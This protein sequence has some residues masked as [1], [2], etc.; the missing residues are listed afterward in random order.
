MLKNV[1]YFDSD[2]CTNWLNCKC[3]RKNILWLYTF[4]NLITM[5]DELENIQVKKE[6]SESLI[7]NFQKIEKNIE[8]CQYKRIDQVRVNIAEIINDLE[9]HT[10]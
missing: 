8:K 10:N 4:K 5:T 6:V 3:Y 2:W 9:N 1:E 7:K